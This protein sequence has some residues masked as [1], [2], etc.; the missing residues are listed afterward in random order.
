M[1]GSVGI[2]KWGDKLLGIGMNYLIFNVFD[3]GKILNFKSLFLEILDLVILL[4]CLID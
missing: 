2:C 4:N 1:G 3:R